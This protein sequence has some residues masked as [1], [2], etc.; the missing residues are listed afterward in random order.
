MKL[1]KLT[2]L[3]LP[4]ALT[5]CIISNVESGR[6]YKGVDS[7][8]MSSMNTEITALCIKNAW[9]NTDV[10]MEVTA[11]G[12]VQRK[13]GDMI[14]LYTLNYLEMVDILPLDNEKSKVLFYHNGEK[15]WGTK[16]KLI[17]AIKG[18]L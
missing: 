6:A 13:T 14:T 7:E 12:V 18:C 3:I 4:V 2:A 5:G 16:Q 17:S 10:H 1:Y 9:E 8:Y 15:I 11:R